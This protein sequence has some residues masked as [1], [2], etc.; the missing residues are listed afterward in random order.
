MSGPT[1]V[2]G[3]VMSGRG[4]ATALVLVVAVTACGSGA[5]SAEPAPTSPPSTSAP[6]TAPATSS[7]PQTTAGA[8]AYATRLF[9][10]PIDVVLPAYVN[11]KPTEEN[12]NFV[13][14]SAPDDS[15]AV[16]FLRP[17]NLYKPGSSTS[18]PVPA[19]Y[20]PYLMGQADHGAHFADRRET[21]VDGHPATVFTVTTSQSI[22]GSLGCP[23]RGIPADKCYG[24]QPEFSVPLAVVKS[25]SGPLLI[26]LRIP[27]DAPA[28]KA[29]GRQRL[30]DLLAGVRF[31]DRPV[32]SA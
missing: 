30:D 3:L 24:I 28:L 15:I 19:D 27:S 32:G 6:S 10:P 16:R 9:D 31:A 21:T 2:R 26:W 1:P 29:V 22:D 8:G 20:V 4:V 17:D 14:W 12:A 25:A 7:T 23:G 13:T 11:R 18:G 5:R